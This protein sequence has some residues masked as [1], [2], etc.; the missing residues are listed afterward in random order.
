MTRRQGTNHVLHA[1]LSVLTLGIW[2][3]VW[4]TVAVSNRYTAPVLCT[5]CGARIKRAV[6][7][8]A[9]A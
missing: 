3:L 4:I 9:Q 1:L 8:V 7:R 2:V 6:A 5:R